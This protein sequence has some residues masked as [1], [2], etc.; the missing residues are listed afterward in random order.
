[1]TENFFLRSTYLVIAM[2]GGEEAG[3]EVTVH[4]LVLAHLV[5]A[6]SIIPLDFYIVFIPG[7]CL[8]KI[9]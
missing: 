9:F 3:D 6:L 8:S 7:P 5:H 4:I 2:D 1:M